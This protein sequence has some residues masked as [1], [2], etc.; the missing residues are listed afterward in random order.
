MHGSASARARRITIC[1]F[2]LFLRSRIELGHRAMVGESRALFSLPISLLAFFYF[3]S[4]SLFSAIVPDYPSNYSVFFSSFTFFFFA[5]ATKI[6][7]Q[8]CFVLC[9]SFSSLS[10]SLSLL[11]SRCCW[12][13]KFFY[14]YMTFL[15]L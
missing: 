9:H 4:R 13:V 5:A 11:C 7:F 1:A 10:H 6:E 2:L 12:W 3:D 14:S 15:P 8:P